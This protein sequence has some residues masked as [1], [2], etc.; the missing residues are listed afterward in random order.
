MSGRKLKEINQDE[1]NEYVYGKEGMSV[2][3][4]YLKDDKHSVDAEPV[5]EKLNKEFEKELEVYKINGEENELLMKGFMI[6]ALPSL[7]IFDNG[8]LMDIKTGVGNYESL[9]R[10]IRRTTL[11]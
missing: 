8:R 4:L 11:I 5:M 7:V 6:R 10:F 3:F 2:L 9:L 1:F